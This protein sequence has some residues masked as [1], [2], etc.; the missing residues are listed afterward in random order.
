MRRRALLLPSAAVFVSVIPAVAALCALAGQAAR[1]ALDRAAERW[2]E[3]TKKKLTLDEKIGQLIVP[4][5]ESAYVSTDSDTFDQLARLV[6]E[7]LVGDFHIFGASVPAPAVLLNPTYGTVVLGQP[8]AA[9]FLLNRL[10]ALSALPLLNTADFEGGVGFRMAGGTL[11]P[12][13]MAMG[14]V[15]G[16]DALRL[17]REEARLTGIEARA[18]GVH[19]NFA[20][21]ADVNNNPRNPVINTRSYGED[22]RRVPL[23]SAR[24]SRA[25]GMP[26]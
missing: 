24:I 3:Q 25:R 18:I 9:A 14:A 20:P 2:V 21:V 5:F 11:F 8:F 4:S 26:A 7:Y 19:V 22:P 10:Q 6:R 13:Q 12:R 1:P 17:V 15:A 23:S 16:A